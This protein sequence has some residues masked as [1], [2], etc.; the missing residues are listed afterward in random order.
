MSGRLTYYGLALEDDARP[1]AIM[2]ATVVGTVGAYVTALI[3][4][5]AKFTTVTTLYVTVVIFI[6]LGASRSVPAGEKPPEAVALDAG[7]GQLGAALTSSA[8]QKVAEAASKA[9]EDVQAGATQLARGVTGQDVQSGMT[10]VQRCIEGCKSRV[11]TALRLAELQQRY[12]ECQEFLRRLKTQVGDALK[13]SL[14]A[15]AET[16]KRRLEAA[17]GFFAQVTQLVMTL[18]SIGSL[19]VSTAGAA[20]L[21]AAAIVWTCGFVPIFDTFFLKLKE[22]LDFKVVA[23]APCHRSMHV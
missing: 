1:P 12:R 9:A 4:I 7:F 19:L 8:Q 17:T 14:K 13:A 6:A 22:A 16:V 21:M 3:I 5:Q 10:R 2:A 20:T 18:A 15:A 11:S 23:A